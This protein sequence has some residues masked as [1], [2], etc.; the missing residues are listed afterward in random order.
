MAV[1][2]FDLDETLYDEQQF[3]QGGMRVVA[4]YLSRTLH[5]SVDLLFDELMKE[6]KVDRSGVFDRLL[7]KRATFTKKL[8]KKCISIYRSHQPNLTLYPEAEHCL[9]RLKDYPKYVVSDGNQR[10]QRSKFQA[11]KLKKSIK[12]CICTYSYGKKYSKPS[13]YV[14]YKICQWEGVEP[15][16]II[17]VGDNPM[18]DFVGLKPAGFRTIRVLKGAHRGIKVDK[19]HEAEMIIESLDELKPELFE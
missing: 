5:E 6:V 3:I 19:A 4:D 10:V 9:R 7:K 15:K 8:V 13:P 14:F 18:K 11:L 2:V 17:Y 16:E 1:F 12:K